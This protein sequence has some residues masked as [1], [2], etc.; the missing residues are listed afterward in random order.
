MQQK[1]FVDQQI[2]IEIINQT[3][4][5]QG[6]VRLRVL[7]VDS[8]LPSS[9]SEGEDRAS[10]PPTPLNTSLATLYLPGRRA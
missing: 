6:A 5:C 1:E 2:S 9:T 8:E 7:F 4:F 3:H 10:H